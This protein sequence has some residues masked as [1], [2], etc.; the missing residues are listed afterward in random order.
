M[1]KKTT[2]RVSE[3]DVVCNS[4]IGKTEELAK[5]LAN[6]SGYALRVT[7]RDSEKYIGTMDLRFDRINVEIDNG[8]VTK[9]NVG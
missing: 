7:R 9:S 6:S 1:R 5:S 4:L 2:T 8:L 3:M